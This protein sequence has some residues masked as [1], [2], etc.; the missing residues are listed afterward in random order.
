[1][2]RR[3]VRPYSEFG[4]NHNYSVQVVFEDRFLHHSYGE[5]TVSG[6][7][8]SEMVVCSARLRSA[9]CG[10]GMEQWQSWIDVDEGEVPISYY[11]LGSEGSLTPL[12]A[13]DAVLHCRYVFAR[14]VAVRLCSKYDSDRSR[15]LRV[16]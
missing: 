9:W 16:G 5:K 10:A 2:Y 7:R 14:K 11:A 15:F 1:M 12:R 8:G 3:D 4:P 13:F 6:S